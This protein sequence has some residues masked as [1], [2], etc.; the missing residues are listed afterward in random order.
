MKGLVGRKVGMTQ[1]FSSEGLMIPVTVIEVESNVVTQV[2]TAE[3]DGYEAVQIGYGL[4]K[5]KSVNKP[6]K[7]HF[8]KAGVTPR[9]SLQEFRVENAGSFTIGQE[10][11]ADLFAVGDKVDITGLSKGKGFTGVIKRH[12]QRKGPESHGSRYHRRPGSMGSNTSPGRV[13]KGKNLAG[14]MG[15]E[16]VTVQNLE[17]VKIDTERN[18]LLVKG[19]VPGPK[20]GL[21]TIKKTIKQGR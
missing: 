13:F 1:I 17:V 4:A 14:H 2:K 20:K 7:G 6:L 3:T 18:V 11:L 10:V 19:A 12:G 15:H 9:R 5:T 16:Q 21:L 8:D